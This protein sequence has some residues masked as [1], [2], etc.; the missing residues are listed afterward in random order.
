MGYCNKCGQRGH[1]ANR[2]RVPKSSYKTAQNYNYNHLHLKNYNQ[3]QKPHGGQAKGNGGGNGSGGNRA[4]GFGETAAEGPVADSATH[5]IS[6]GTSHGIARIRKRARKHDRK[7]HVTLRKRIMVILVIT[8]FMMILV[9]V[10]VTM[11][12]LVMKLIMVLVTIRLMMM[13][14]IKQPCVELISELFGWKWSIM[15]N[16]YIPY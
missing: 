3:P 14:S 7:D 5:A 1:K 9:M 11:S 12:I 6:R 4:Y 16:S 13:E 15:A 10:L 8:I 2:C